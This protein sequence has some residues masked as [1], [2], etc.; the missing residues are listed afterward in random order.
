MSLLH[1]IHGSV[2]PFALRETNWVLGPLLYTA[3]LF[4]FYLVLR[5]FFLGVV[6]VRRGSGFDIGAKAGDKVAGLG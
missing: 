6:Q 1:F 4:L 3:F 2:D 5:S